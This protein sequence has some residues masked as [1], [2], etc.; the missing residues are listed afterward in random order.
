MLNNNQQITEA[1]G[2]ASNILITFRNDSGDGFSSALALAKILEKMGKKAD[3]TASNFKVP[4]HLSFLPNLNKVSSELGGL[5]KFIISLDISRTKV[6]EISYDVKG[7]NLEFVISPKTGFFE[8]Q[9]ITTDSSG[10][11]YDLIFV[12][13]CADLES[14][15]KIYDCDTE[16][17]YKTPIVNIDNSAANENFGQIKL[18]DVT[19]SSCAEIIFNLLEKTHRELIDGEVA[20]CLLSGII[21]NTKNF[22]IKTSPLTLSI[23]SQLISMGAKRE[24]IV[25]NFYQART[26]GTLKLWGRAL[27]RIQNEKDKKLVWSILKA[28]D[29]EKTGTKEENLDDVVEELIVNAE[30][31]EIIAIIYEKPQVVAGDGISGHNPAIGVI[32]H[33]V[34]SVNALD[35]AK[36]FSG[37]GNEDIARFTLTD[38]NLQQ[39]EEEVIG[40]I[41]RKLGT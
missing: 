20:T 19:A 21:A 5:R 22:K 14:L 10:F 36:K 28:E 18:I 39:V 30:E 40:E 31:A 15:G 8:P 4:Q 35:L 12:I 6:D 34:K 13:G 26:I 1:L 23:S 33:S 25:Q 11:K 29:F 27:A 17:F 7:N 41:K 24:E 9:D 3:V 16:F 32:L 38:K 2:S 37:Q